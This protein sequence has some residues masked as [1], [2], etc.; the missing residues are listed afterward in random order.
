[1]I[2]PK[3][4]FQVL[5]V[6]VLLHLRLVQ[7][8]SYLTVEWQQMLLTA[9]IL[10]SSHPTVSQ[11]CRLLC[12]ILLLWPSIQCWDCPRHSLD[13]FSPRVS[14]RNL[15]VPTPSVTL[16][17]LRP[18]PK[19]PLA[20]RGCLKWTSVSE[21]LRLISWS[22]SQLSSSPDFPCLHLSSSCTSQKPRNYPFSYLLL[23][24]Y[25]PSASLGDGS[26]AHF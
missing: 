2:P 1:M 6:C 7:L 15:I 9:R 21:C 12:G 17:L 19:L 13:V 23:N 14:L 3:Q 26:V 18:A 24:S 4:V 11:N 10:K 8:S 25:I 5:N 16:V 22:S 20:P